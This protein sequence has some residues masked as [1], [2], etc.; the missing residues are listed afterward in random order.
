ME[1]EGTVSV[2]DTVGAMKR[3]VKAVLAFDISDILTA[4]NTRRVIHILAAFVSE[5]L[6]EVGISIWKPVLHWPCLQV[7]MRIV[8][9][10][11]RT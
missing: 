5:K 3:S 2:E 11:G 6:V 9:I 1:G 10:K 8:N 7:V 4:A